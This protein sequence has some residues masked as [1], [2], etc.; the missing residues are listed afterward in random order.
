MEQIWEETKEKGIFDTVTRA[1][2]G[3]ENLDVIKLQNQ[4]AG[5]LRCNFESEFNV[6]HRASQLKNSLMNGG[7]ILVILDDVW[8]VI[9]LDVIGISFGDGIS[10]KGCKILMKSREQDVCLRNNCKHA[11]KITTLTDDEA[12]D[13]FRYIVSNPQIDSLQDE[14][15][16][17]KVCKKCAGLPLLIRAVGKAVQ[18]TSH[19]S[20]KDALCQLEKG[21]FENIVGINPQ[22]Y[23][24]IKLSIDRIPED[25]R[26][27]LF[28]CSLFP[29][30]AGIDIR[31]LI[32][33]AAGSELV[34][35][36]ESRIRAM[37]DFLVSSLLLDCLE[38]HIVKLHDVIRDVGRSIAVSDLR[39]AFL[40]VKC[41]SRL[42]VN[43][44][45]GTRKLIRLDVDSYE[46]HF[47]NDLVYPHLHS[48]WLNCNK[49]T[50]QLSGGV[51][52]LF[53]N[54]TFLWIQRVF[55]PLRQQFSL[56]P[57][58]KLRTLFLDRCYI[59][60]TDNFFPENLETLCIW[61]CHLPSQLHLPDLKYLRKLE[62]LGEVLHILPDT[63]SSLSSLEELHIPYGFEI[64]GDEIAV[65]VPILV[66]ISKL[67]RLTSLTMFFK[68]SEPLQYTDI[69]SN[70]LEFHICVGKQKVNLINRALPVVPTRLIEVSG[71][72]LEGLEILIE[73]AEYLILRCTDVKVSSICNRNREAF[74]DLRNLYI[75][76]CD[77][78]EHLARISQNEIQLIC[79]K[80]TSFSKLTN[81]EIKNCSTME[82]LFCNSVAKCLMQLEKLSIFNCPMM[83]VIVKNEGRS[84]GDVI[85][86][87]K[88]KS[89]ILVKMQRLTRMSN[90]SRKS[91]SY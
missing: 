53:A 31:T 5:Y 63:I 54:L 42:P 64:C 46:V 22:V 48:L 27:C 25:A 1:D 29:E 71:Y 68:D 6:E 16:A 67:S 10:S 9:P 59:S 2:V 43:N 8:S 87:S 26:S 70:L 38:H 45:Y 32:Q 83:E 75:Q 11:V 80:R 74:A 84:G 7:K 85:N 51:S 34:R 23:A 69:F 86:F 61:Y 78:M 90:L 57:L 91:E 20:W 24:C 89:L 12:W 50:R 14:S 4:I 49:H 39:Y 15:L 36:G 35:D 3:S 77:T 13:L 21:K 65:P 88:L 81:L 79:Q 40:H 58:V 44:D 52:N 82:Y 56:Q 72:Q 73:R 37:I 60:K 19:N 55:F 47:P 18:F 66:E 33:L 41:G 28:L 30:D 76:R 62:V 17:Q